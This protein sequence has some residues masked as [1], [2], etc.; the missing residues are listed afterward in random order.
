[1]RKK[2]YTKL[3]K[4][5]RKNFMEIFGCLFVS[6]KSFITE[7]LNR[8]I[9]RTDDRLS[10]KYSNIRFNLFVYYIYLFIHKVKVSLYLFLF[11]SCLFDAI[12]VLRY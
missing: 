1:M 2:I 8:L 9:H 11:M 4:N 5:C 6:N 12:V 10:L 7:I 3:K